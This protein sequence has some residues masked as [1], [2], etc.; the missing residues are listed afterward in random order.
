MEQFINWL[1]KSSEDFQFIL[2]FGILGVLI[3]AEQ[4]LHFRPATKKKRWV[5]NLVLTLIAIVTMLALPITFISAARFAM[6]KQWGLLNIIK[7]HWIVSF[8]LTIFLRGF[9]SFITHYAMHKIPLFWRIH[10]VHHLDTE[11]DVSTTVRFHPFEFLVNIAI[12][13]PII[14]LFGFPVWPLLLYELLDIAVTLISHSN[15]QIPRKLDSI[16]RYIIVTPNLHRIHHSAH[17]PETD[18]NFSAVF[19]VWDILFGTFRTKTRIPSK[20]MELGLEEIRDNRT[21]N[22]LWLLLSPFKTF[23]KKRKVDK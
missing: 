12:G 14:I 18:S 20:A 11:M 9:I 22:I 19:P 10:R 6:V 23:Q 4:I 3:V 13:V 7:V 2:Y 8:I 15:I 16:L 17:Q 5:A 21:S 1:L